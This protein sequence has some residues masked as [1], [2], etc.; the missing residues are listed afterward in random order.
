MNLNTATEDMQDEAYE[1]MASRSKPGPILIFSFFILFL[2]VS[3]VYHDQPLEIS[4]IAIAL[5]IVSTVRV[6]NEFGFHKFYWRNKTLWKKL[7]ASTISLN[8]FVWGMFCLVVVGE[9]GIH[10]ISLLILICTAGISAGGIIAV[11]PHQKL[12]FVFQSLILLPTAFYSFTMDSAAAY[13]ISYMFLSYLIFMSLMS[14]KLHAEYWAAMENVRLLDKRAKELEIARDEAV[15]LAKI[16]SDFLATMSHELRTPMNGILGMS[17]LLE[18]SNLTEEQQEYVSTIVSSTNLLL[19]IIN[20]ILDFSKMESGNVDLEHRHF[21]IKELLADI[22][23]LMNPAINEKQLTFT[24]DFDKNCP[25]DFVGDQGRIRQV[26]LNLLGN[27]IKF[28]TQGSISIVVSCASNNRIR[29][30]VVDTGIG[31]D[32]SKQSQIFSA[33]TQADASTTRKYGGTGLGLAISRQ[34]VELMDG[35]IGIESQVGKGSTFWFEIPLASTGINKS[36]ATKTSVD[37]SEKINDE[38]TFVLDNNIIKQLKETME[39]QYPQL[40]ESHIRSGK[41]TM[42]NILKSMQNN[43]ID[44]L[45]TYLNSLKSSSASIGASMLEAETSFI[46][47]QLTKT[48]KLPD[49]AEYK[50][51]SDLFDKMVD[52]LQNSID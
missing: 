33:F 21:N 39:D 41:D 11:I 34:L 9:Y 30:A 29:F 49:Q 15:Q 18:L 31:I 25:E 50:K 23:K 35:E 44:D 37:E 27:A 26:L 5:L 45:K 19:S 43:N 1:Y 2:F 36:Q 16:K 10:W 32:A 8:A 7:Y 38:D 14:R 47:K 24:I 17:Q 28:T 42:E 13:S 52:A 12:S 20:S 22:E 51:L 40:I 4:I 46:E 48:G 3:P 6:I